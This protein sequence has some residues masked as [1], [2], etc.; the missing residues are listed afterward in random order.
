MLHLAGFHVGP[1]RSTGLSTTYRVGERFPYVAGEEDGCH[2]HG[3]D[4]ED[5]VQQASGDRRLGLRAQGATQPAGRGA[6][7]AA[8]QVQ[9]THPL[10]ANQPTALADT[11]ELSELNFNFQL[12]NCVCVYVLNCPGPSHDW[13]T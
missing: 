1:G 12:S 13:I 6:Q 10:P 8:Q 2:Q 4:Q 5:H 3:H 11:G 9:A 7:A